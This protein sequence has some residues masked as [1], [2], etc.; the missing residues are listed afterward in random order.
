[1]QP[2]CSERAVYGSPQDSCTVAAVYGSPE[3]LRTR[4]GS[5]EGGGVR[6]ATRAMIAMIAISYVNDCNLICK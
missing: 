4:R 5:G 2:L 3:E 1:M 6:L